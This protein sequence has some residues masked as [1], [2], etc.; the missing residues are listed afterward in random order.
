MRGLEE[1]DSILGDS[2]GSLRWVRCMFLLRLPQL[3]G[4]K[5]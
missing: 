5:G 3:H 4:E 1:L 2:M